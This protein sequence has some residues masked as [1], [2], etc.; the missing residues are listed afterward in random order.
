[1]CALMKKVGGRE[2]AQGKTGDSFAGSVHSDHPPVGNQPPLLH[3][4]SVAPSL[5]VCVAHVGAIICL[6]DENH[7]PDAGGF[8]PSCVNIIATRGPDRLNS[9][10]VAKCQTHKHHATHKPYCWSFR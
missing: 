5:A 8:T 2:R 4:S 6:D 3:T 1:M 7:C 10:V 9:D